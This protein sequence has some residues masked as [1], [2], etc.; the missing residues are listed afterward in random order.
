MLDYYFDGFERVC[1]DHK[2]AFI[3]PNI[4]DNEVARSMSCH[5]VPLPDAFYIDASAFIISKNSP[6]KG[7]STGG[8]IMK[9]SQLDT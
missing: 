3:G 1:F 8:E 9:L 7:L 2:F 5:L 4:L 6:Y